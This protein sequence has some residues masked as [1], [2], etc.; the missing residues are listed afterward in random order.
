MLQRRGTT[1]EVYLDGALVASDT[2]AA[3]NADISNTLSFY[4]GRLGA[5]YATG[6]L[7]DFRVYD[8]ALLLSE[9]HALGAP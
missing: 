7:D 4:L 2:N 5:N 8:R 1:F 9:I 6:T 3:N